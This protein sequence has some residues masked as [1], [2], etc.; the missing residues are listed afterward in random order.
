[1]NINE[2]TAHKI[3]EFRLKLNYKSKDVAKALEIER[4]NYSKLEN[5]K[6][7]ITLKKLELIANFF[8]IPIQSFVGSNH[9][10]NISVTNGEHSPI[11]NANVINNIDPFLVE[12][13]KDTIKSLTKTVEILQK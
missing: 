10:Q 2:L 4:A 3:K 12:T 13:L 11:Q 5:G 9:N 7:E 1:M 6:T 8:K